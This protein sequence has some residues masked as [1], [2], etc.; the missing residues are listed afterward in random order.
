MSYLQWDDH[1]QNLLDGWVAKVS[2]KLVADRRYEDM[3]RLMS[4]L[5]SNEMLLSSIAIDGDASQVWL[6]LKVSELAS[7]LSELGWSGS[8]TDD[9]VYALLQDISEFVRINDFEN[10]VVSFGKPQK[11]LLPESNRPRMSLFVHRS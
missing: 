10:A 6:D 9:D 8:V 11:L 5:N 2:A 4:C 7:T 1:Y 3:I